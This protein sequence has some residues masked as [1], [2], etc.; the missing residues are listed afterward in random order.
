MKTNELINYIRDGKLDQRLSDIYLDNLKMDY[1]RS[2]YIDAI[3]KYSE[4]YGEDS[5]DVEIY[6]APGRTEVGVNHTDHQHGQVLAASINDD[7][8]AIVSKNS[9]ETVNVKSE[10]YDMIDESL[11]TRY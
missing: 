4:I 5:A 10:G 11:K 1:Q 8:I 7:A 9:S 2:R 6:S 3:A